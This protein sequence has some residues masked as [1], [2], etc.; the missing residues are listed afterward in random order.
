[1]KRFFSLI[2]L[3]LCIFLGVVTS[4]SA[5]GSGDPG[6]LYALFVI[7]SGIIVCF[8]CLFDD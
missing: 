3:I 4:I 1:M 6:Y 7:A 2:G 8:K 5:Y